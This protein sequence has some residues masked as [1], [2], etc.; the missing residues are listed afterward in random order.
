MWQL[1]TTCNSSS[2]EPTPSSV[3]CT[4]VVH[5]HTTKIKINSSL[6][7][8]LWGLGLF[9]LFTLTSHSH[10]AS[11][12][13]TCV[14]R[15]KENICMKPV[16]TSATSAGELPLPMYITTLMDSCLFSPNSL[17]F[18]FISSLALQCPKVVLLLLQ[19]FK[20]SL[21]VLVKTVRYMW[22]NLSSIN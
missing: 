20:L 10:S 1:T 9:L 18:H 16:I 4:H 12:C 13:P 19:W 7:W 2:R 11:P 5:I 17:S 6:K 15:S 22:R 3:L 14:C 21:F 8:S